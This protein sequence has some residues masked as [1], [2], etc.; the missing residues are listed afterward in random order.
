[1][2]IDLKGG[3]LMN[4][5]PGGVRG[6]ISLDRLVKLLREAGEFRPNE[7]VTHLEFTPDG[8]AYRVETNH[9]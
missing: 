1:M 6:G 4:T 3:L 9:H 7:T 2:V 8:V 5:M